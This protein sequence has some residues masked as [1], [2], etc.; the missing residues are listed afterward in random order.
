MGPAD[1]GRIERVAM[2]VVEELAGEV[3]GAV[4]R[5]DFLCSKPL[6]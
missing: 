5:G 3:T 4:A 6:E 2:N 1:A